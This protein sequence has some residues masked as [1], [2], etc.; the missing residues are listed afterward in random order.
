MTEFEQDGLAGPPDAACASA[1]RLGPGRGWSEQP[2]G[3]GPAVLFPPRVRRVHRLEE[4]DKLLARLV[5][6]LDPLEE[7]VEVLFE[8]GGATLAVGASA[9]RRT[10]D[11]QPGEGGDA[12]RFTGVWDLRKQAERL[13]GFAATDEDLGQCDDG[14]GKVRLELE[15]PAQRRLIADCDQLLGLARRREQP[16]H[17][18]ADGGLAEAHR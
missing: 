4:V 10:R 5:V 18:L 2:G 8:L 17:E 14:G 12:A 6:G 15:R 16:V 11:G 3:E 13:L 9:A 7:R 1:A